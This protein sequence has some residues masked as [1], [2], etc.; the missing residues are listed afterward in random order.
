MT[1]ESAKRRYDS[2]RRQ[3]QAQETRGRILEAARRLFTT[4]GYA[5]T[6]MEALAQEADVAVETV[7]A[8]FQSKRTV[9]V[10][11]VDRLVLGDEA[12]KPLLA[13]AGPQQVMAARDQREQLQLF[14]RS[15]TGIIARVGPIFV[16]VRAAALTEPEI[17]DLLQQMLRGRRETMQEIPGWLARNGPLRAGLTLAAAADTIWAIASPEMYHLLTVDAGWSQER[18]AAWLSDT[19]SAILLPAGA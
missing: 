19:L 17:G 10:R 4:R 13:Q 5:G 18:F 6:T 15:F 2:S 9:L 12:P 1:H 16:V 14:A 3:A 7:Y 8:G 11:L